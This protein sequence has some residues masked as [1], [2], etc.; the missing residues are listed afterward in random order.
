MGEIRKPTYIWGFWI[1][2][3][4]SQGR[5]IPRL[6]RFSFWRFT[7][8]GP[9]HRGEALQSSFFEF[10]ANHVDSNLIVAFTHVLKN[11]TGLRLRPV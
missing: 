1:Y 9:R 6:P 2:R 5:T 10:L 7:L 8:E 11:M 3:N 4:E